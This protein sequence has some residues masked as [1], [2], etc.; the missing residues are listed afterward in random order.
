MTAPRKSAVRLGVLERI[1]AAT[2]AA[3]APSGYGP[4]GVEPG[5]YVAL[6]GGGYVEEVR[7]ER[8][9]G[10]GPGTVLRATSAGRDLLARWTA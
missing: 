9:Y 5:Y 2:D 7:V 8:G 10:L 6:V 1:V 3:P 4:L